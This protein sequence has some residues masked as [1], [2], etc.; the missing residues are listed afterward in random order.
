MLPLEAID[1][2]NAKAK[3]FERY[4]ITCVEELVSFFPRKYEDY[5]ARKNI[6]DLREG[7]VCRI[8]GT[9]QCVNSYDRTE[10]IIDDGTGTLKLIWFGYCYFKSELVPGSNWSFCGKITS[11]RG[12]LQM[13]HP[14]FGG[15]GFDALAKIYPFY[16]K[17]N[18]MS[19][20]YLTE[21]IHTGLSVLQ[22]NTIWTEE[23]AVAHR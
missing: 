13:T 22:A 1:V 2:S 15:K 5:R 12:L 21:K 18:G 23:D 3:Q 9:I 20:Q 16:K 6:C 17:I 10:A 14:K 4:G 8:S 7:D 11:F 19:E